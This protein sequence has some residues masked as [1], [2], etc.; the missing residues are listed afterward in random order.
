MHIYKQY[1]YL[2]EK[3][4]F[5]TEQPLVLVTTISTICQFTEINSG[6]ERSKDGAGELDWSDITG[7]ARG[8]MCVC[9]NDDRQHRLMQPEGSVLFRA[10]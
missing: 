7:K 4:A 5:E 10:L 2:C 9:V 1:R 8:W 3:D 6:Q